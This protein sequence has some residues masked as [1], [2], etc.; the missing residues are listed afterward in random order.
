MSHSVAVRHNFETGHRLPHL[1]AEKC[2]ALHGHSWW[3][4]VEVSRSYLD[5]DGCVVEFGDLKKHLRAWIDSRLDHG[6]M[7]G[8]ADPLTDILPNYGKCFIFGEG[9]PDVD[10][11]DLPWPTVENVAVLLS[12]VTTYILNEMGAS[13]D[14]FCSR[15]TVNETHVNTATWTH[16]S[17]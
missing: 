4:E 1:A 13:R 8:L 12:R 16:D 2:H 6:L 5:G 11:D 14:T 3:V 10:T 9:G 17:R 7:L 15:V